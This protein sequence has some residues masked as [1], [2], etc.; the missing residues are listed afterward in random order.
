MWQ[1]EVQLSQGHKDAAAVLCGAVLEEAL[2]GMCTKQDIPTKEWDT[3]G[4]LSN[5]LLNKGVYEESMHR[6][7][8]SWWYLREDAQSVNF[9]AYDKEDVAGMVRG[10]QDFLKSCSAAAVTSNPDDEG[11]GL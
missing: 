3:I 1:A 11:K 5:G 2:R 6:K 10:V 8:V 7:I 4:D 9:D